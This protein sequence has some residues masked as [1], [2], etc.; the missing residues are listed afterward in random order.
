M[1]GEAVNGYLALFMTVHTEAH[2]EIDVAVRHRSLADI[3]VAGGALDL[4]ANVRRVI[5]PHMRL[6]RVAVDALPDEI[7]AARAHRGELEDARPIGGDGVVADHARAHA[8]QPGDRARRHRFVAILGAADLL[9]D[10]DVVRELQ[11]L[12][13]GGT[14]AE[15]IAERRSGGRTSGREDGTALSRQQR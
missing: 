11:R 12:L 3:A 9:P 6:R 10:M 15:K 7:L 13:R 2:V 1:T 8:R 14:P 4:G 5:E